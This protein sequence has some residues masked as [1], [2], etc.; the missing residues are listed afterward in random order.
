MQFHLLTS[1]SSSNVKGKKITLLVFSSIF[2]VLGPLCLIFFNWS[3]ALM[4]QITFALFNNTTS[5]QYIVMGLIGLFL[6][7]GVFLGVLGLKFKL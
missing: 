5:A 1:M 4:Q 6:I 3:T 7:L 2:I